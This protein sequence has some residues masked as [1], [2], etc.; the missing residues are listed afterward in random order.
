MR[1]FNRVEA[2]SPDPKQPLVLSLGNFD[3]VH[4]G[5]QL[6]LNRNLES[7]RS[8]QGKAAV[9]TF[10]KHP[11]AV[12]HPEARPRL[13]TSTPHK[14]YLLEKLG[15][16]FCFLIPFTESFSKIT[17][18][19]FIKNI[20]VK[21]LGVRKVVLGYNAR[22]GRGRKGDAALMKKFSLALGFEFEE[23]PAVQ[24]AGET[25]SSTRVRSLVEKGLIEE[26]KVCLKRPFSVFGKVI[27]GEGRGKS[28][29]FPT[30]NLNIDAEIL[31]P[32]GVYP[33]RV[34]QL[35]L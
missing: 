10:E 35:D 25:V 29:G 8:I 19:D 26:A 14:I 18:E 1:I 28:L 20:L 3:G 31:P 4:A 12:L 23:V 11:Q 24:I 5:H 13:L 27:K 21:H 34:Q 33:V 6:I 22:F 2:F 9:F 15:L 30:A 16:D 17:T 32:F 7:A